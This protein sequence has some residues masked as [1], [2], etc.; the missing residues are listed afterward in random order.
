MEYKLKNIIWDYNFSEEQLND[1]LSGRVPK[2]GS[3]TRRDL[4]T[5]MLMYLNWFDIIRF[6]N[7]DIFLENFNE[8]FIKSLKD[9]DL[10][11]GLLFVREFL[12]K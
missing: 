4:Y 3:M 2:L 1:L 12:L 8:E 11:K 5:R 10:Q 9:T 7:K 6:V